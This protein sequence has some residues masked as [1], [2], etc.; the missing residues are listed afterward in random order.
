MLI[1][2]DKLP[3]VMEGFEA[4]ISDAGTIDCDQPEAGR[5]GRF[6]QQFCLYA[7][8]SLAVK[9]NKWITVTVPVFTPGQLPASSQL[10]NL[11][12]IRLLSNGDCVACRG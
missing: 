4:R 7:R 11:N 9:I 6:M 5:K 3:D 2:T 1:V 10:Q 12:P 8:P